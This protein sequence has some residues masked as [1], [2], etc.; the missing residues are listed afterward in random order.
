M[1]ALRWKFVEAVLYSDTSEDCL[2][3]IL[4]FKGNILTAPKWQ[5]HLQFVYDS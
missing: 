5:T 3:S 1:L 4:R 2:V